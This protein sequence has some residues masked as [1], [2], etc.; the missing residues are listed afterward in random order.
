MTIDQI[1]A[2]ALELTRPER[3]RLAHRRLESLEDHESDDPAEVE[4]AWAAEIA[5]CIAELDAGRVDA[6][7]LEQILAGIR[8]EL[9]R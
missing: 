4:A 8:A 2:A 6:V 9:A 7:P 1:E 3:A 5:Q